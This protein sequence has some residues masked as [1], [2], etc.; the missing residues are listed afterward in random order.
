MANDGFMNGHQIVPKQYLLDATDSDLQPGGFKKGQ[1]S[2]NYFGYGYQTWIM[3]FKERTFSLQ[4]I[5]GQNI[6]IQPSSK[7][8][9]VQTSVYEKPSADPN[10]VLQLDLFKAAVQALGGNPY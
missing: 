1:A 6:F 4:G 3:G 9:L 7:V 10:W 2:Y 5:Y 8:V